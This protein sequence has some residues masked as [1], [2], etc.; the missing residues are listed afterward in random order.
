MAHVVLLSGGRAFSSGRRRAFSSGRGLMHL[1]FLFRASGTPHFSPTGKY[2][3][4]GVLETVRL[5][6]KLSCH[7]WLCLGT[8]SFHISKSSPSWGWLAIPAAQA[9]RILPFGGGGELGGFVAWRGLVW[10]SSSELVQWLRGPMYP[11]ITCRVHR[12]RDVLST[13][14]CSIPCCADLLPL[15]NLWYFSSIHTDGEK[16]QN[17]ERQGEEVDSMGQQP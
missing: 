17:V 13:L 12:C 5:S 6:G 9:P 15:P 3:A 2:K 7:L 4:D 11:L 14:S 10:F 1:L 8:I 16:L